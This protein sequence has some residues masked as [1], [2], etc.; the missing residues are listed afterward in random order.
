M[1]HTTQRKKHQVCMKMQ[2]RRRMMQQWQY[3]LQEDND[4]QKAIVTEEKKLV[5]KKEA[6]ANKKEAEVRSKKHVGDYLILWKDFKQLGHKG[7]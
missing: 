6:K 4:Q 5:R 2:G 1:V 3:I 7:K